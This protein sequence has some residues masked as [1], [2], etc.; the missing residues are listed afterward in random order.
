M[1]EEVNK[2]GAPKGNQNAAKGRV[3]R[4]AINRALKLRD[5]SRADGKKALDE[6]AE[7]LI[8]L[9]AAGD[10]AAL[11]ELGDRLEGKA[12]QQLQLTDLDDK[13]LCIIVRGDDVNL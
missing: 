10:M 7:Q 11:K 4:D 5:E 8:T 1:T 2:G 12:A 9:A 13:P 6:I 3:W